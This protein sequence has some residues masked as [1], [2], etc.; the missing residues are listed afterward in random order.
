MKHVADVVDFPPGKRG[1]RE[2]EE[3]APPEAVTITWVCNCECNTFLLHANS[4]VE[5]ANCGTHQAPADV[6][7]WMK[8]LAPADSPATPDRSEPPTSVI[9]LGDP[10]AA[11]RT[12]LTRFDPSEMSVIVVVHREGGIQMW[13]RNNIE[14]EEQLAWLRRKFGAA[15]EMARPRNIG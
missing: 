8:Q 7:Y 6:G 9:D 4:T 13:G 10:A 5:C 2:G 1:G 14:T 12:L 3:A 15:I 11:V